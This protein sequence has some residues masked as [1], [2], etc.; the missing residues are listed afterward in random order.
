MTPAMAAM[1]GTATIPD[2]A[3][4]QGSASTSGV[5][6]VMHPESPNGPRILPSAFSHG[7]NVSRVTIAA[8]ALE[9][10]YETKHIALET[11][12][13]GSDVLRPNPHHSGAWRL[14]FQAES[15]GDMTRR[16]RFHT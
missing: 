14:F 16:N 4:P 9:Q 6:V 2:M 8:I 12:F 3:P 5:Q 10:L 15:H 13:F 11:Y 7:E 1:W